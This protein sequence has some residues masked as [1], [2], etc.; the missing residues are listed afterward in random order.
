MSSD[1]RYAYSILLRCS[2]VQRAMG[3]NEQAASSKND[4]LFF[5]LSLELK[6]KELLENMRR[7]QMM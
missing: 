2:L 6:G 7:E 1:L 4:L 5:H 3:G